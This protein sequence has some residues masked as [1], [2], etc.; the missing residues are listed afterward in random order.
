[1]SWDVVSRHPHDFSSSSILWSAP[2]L[3][4]AKHTH[5]MMRPPPVLHG[6]D[7]VLLLASLPIFPPNITMVIM[8]KQF[9]FCFIRP[10]DI[11]PSCEVAN[12]SLAFLWQFWSSGFFLAERPFRLCRYKTCFTMDI[13]T[14][15]PVSSSIF[16]RSFAAVLGLICTFR[17]K[18]CQIKVYL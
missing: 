7:D 11:S 6:W 1:M 12:H 15:V 2:V 8:A 16:P 4:A 18:V 3:P 14:F 10:E 17:T 9:Y 5:N 13:D